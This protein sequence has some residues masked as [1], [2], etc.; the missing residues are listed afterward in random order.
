MRPLE[1]YDRDPGETY[2]PE[3]FSLAAVEAVPSNTLGTVNALQVNKTYFEVKG[4]L[5][6]K[7]V[8]ARRPLNAPILHKL[9]SSR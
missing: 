9:R 2:Q 7:V 4:G 3:I 6:R 1:H 8:D 5:Y